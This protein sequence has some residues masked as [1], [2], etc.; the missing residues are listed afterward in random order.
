MA[1][2]IRIADRT[3]SLN[4]EVDRY[5]IPMDELGPLRMIDI[6]A[7]S[8]LEILGLPM[9]D[10]DVEYEMWIMNSDED[11]SDEGLSVYGGASIRVTP[12]TAQ[13]AATRLRR[14]FP[15][16]FV[17]GSSCY[18]RISIEDFAGRGMIAD[19]FL[20][21]TFKGK[22][23]IAVSEAIAP[24]VLGFRRLSLPD[25][26][27]ADIDFDEESDEFALDAC[28]PLVLLLGNIGHEGVLSSLSAAKRQYKR[29]MLDSSPANWESI[30]EY[31]TAFRVSTVLVKLTP[32][33][34]RLLSLEEYETV[35]NK[36]FPLVAAVPNTVFVYEDILTGKQQQEEWQEQNYP[37]PARDVL[38]SVFTWFNSIGIELT[39]YR[40]NAEV[41]VL[42]ESFLL[43]TEKNLIF[44]LYIP[45]GRIWSNEADRF[46]QLF[47]DYL[48]R[49]NHL[50][51]RLNQRR[52]DHGIIYEF[53]GD[54]S[55]GETGLNTEFEEFSRFMDLCASNSNAAKALL[56]TKDINH[57]EIIDIIARYS[58]EAKRLQVDLK[59]ERE[60][61]FLAIRQR[62]E[63]ELVDSAPTTTD[64]KAIES[65]INAAIPYSSEISSLLSHTSSPSS[66]IATDGNLTVN[67]RPQIFQRVNGI[68]AQEIYGN[69]HLS[70]NDQQILSLIREHG[71]A[72]AMELESAVHELADDSA[73]KTDRLGA[74]QKLKKF[75]IE[76]GKRTAD[77]AAGVLQTYIENKLGLKS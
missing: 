53:H 61:K 37:Y 69:Q 10:E 56:T 6:P 26:P 77:V 52:T 40:M 17:E 59:H 60:R 44:R 74:K 9:P 48:G 57:K 30:I 32:N 36:L 55:Q 15:D 27:I 67:V 13:H 7:H 8:H 34:F 51:T 33:T 45:N 72:K 38:E 11:G 58:K 39:P 50:T 73:P 43:D 31:F 18:P 41:T 23:E 29:K 16:K 64:W 62:L 1:Q 28:K 20:S 12:E 2:T 75:L 47:R 14:A 42:S 24:F 76:V 49:V 63:S 71:G 4:P 25:D 46:L 65:F 35:R 21:L 66:Y 70:Q 3:Y 22:G 54:A 19:V 68:V 5:Q